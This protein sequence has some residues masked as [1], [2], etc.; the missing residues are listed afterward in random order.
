MKVLQKILLKLCLYLAVKGRLLTYT[1]YYE[2][3]LLPAN[4]SYVITT[5]RNNTDKLIIKK[6]TTSE[7]KLE[8]M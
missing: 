5:L 7:G 2:Q 6:C 1:F 3:C 8:Y 4:H